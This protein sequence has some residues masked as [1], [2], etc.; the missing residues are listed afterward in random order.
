M[1]LIHRLL[2]CLVLWSSVASPVFA[3]SATAPLIVADTWDWDW[4][5]FRK[6]WRNQ[7]GKTTGVVGA[8]GVVVGIGVLIICSAKKKT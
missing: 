1:S 8:A 2:V 7:F 6:F 5:G 4:E 3:E